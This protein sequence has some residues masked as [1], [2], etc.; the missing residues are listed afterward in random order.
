MTQ[1]E[2]PDPPAVS[3][4]I[5]AVTGALALP[6]LEWFRGIKKQFPFFPISTAAGNQVVA[7]PSGS[8]YLNREHLY[9]KSTADVNTVT[10]NG[11][12]GGAVV[13]AAYLSKARFRYDGANWYPA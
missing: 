12:V 4:L 8:V 2:L 3:S 13:L 9:L 6:W 5:S 10:I 1:I 7:L 11:A